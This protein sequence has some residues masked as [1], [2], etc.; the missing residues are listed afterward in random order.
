VINQDTIR[1]SLP[2]P[3]PRAAAR[4][5]AAETDA[6]ARIFF[7][8]GEALSRRLCAEA[9]E[10]LAAAAADRRRRARWLV[11]LFTTVAS[12]VAGFVVFMGG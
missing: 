4:N 5:R 9:E 1:P 3:R 11:L 2:S 7:E 12:G 8:E 10:D 6:L